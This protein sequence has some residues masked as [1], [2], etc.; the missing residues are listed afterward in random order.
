VHYTIATC[1][2]IVILRFQFCQQRL[3]RDLLELHD[4]DMGVNLR[5]ANAHVPQHLLDKPPT[6]RRRT[7]RKATGRCS[8]GPQGGGVDFHEITITVVK[9]TGKNKAA[10][11]KALPL[12]FRSL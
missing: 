12:A 5:G 10:K 8:R 9:A 2:S 6:I 7:R 1:F 11:A 3:F 4:R